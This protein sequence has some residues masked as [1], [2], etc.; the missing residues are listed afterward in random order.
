MSDLLSTDQMVGINRSDVAVSTVHAALALPFINDPLQ[1][2]AS[3]SE[4]GAA[5]VESPIVV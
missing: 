1:T 2:P 4:V 5:L 3:A